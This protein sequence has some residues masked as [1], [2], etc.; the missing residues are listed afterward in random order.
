MPP[1]PM[2]VPDLI[3]WIVFLFFT[4]FR[5]ASS[6]SALLRP[7]LPILFN[8]YLAGSSP[9]TSILTWNGGTLY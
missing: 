4:D 1:S 7:L 3:A 8:G 2:K 5:I 6:P 9:S